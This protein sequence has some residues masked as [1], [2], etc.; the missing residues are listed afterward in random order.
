MTQTAEA[1]TRDAEAWWV[2]DPTL[3]HGLIH[4]PRI[5]A[6][7]ALEPW[8]PLRGRAADQWAAFQDS[9]A[10]QQAARSVLAT[11]GSRHAQLSGPVEQFL[12]RIPADPRFEQHN[13]DIARM[14]ADDA[15][16]AGAQVD[17]VPFAGWLP[18]E[19]AAHWFGLDLAPME[20]ENFSERQTGLL[21]ARHYTQDDQLAALGAAWQLRQACEAAAARPRLD[22]LAAWL[23]DS[24]LPAD[25]VVGLLYGVSIPWVM[26]VKYGILN[27]A[28]QLIG[29]GAWAGLPAARPAQAAVRAALRARP[30]VQMLARSAAQDIPLPRHD[31]TIPAGD[32]VA[33]D[34]RALNATGTVDWTFGVPERHFCTGNRVGR[35][36]I[37]AVIEALAARL[38]DARLVDP[39]P[40]PIDS[41]FH[42]G[43]AR[44][45]IA[46]D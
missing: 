30:P 20:L 10:G 24:G 14:I 40:P 42:S 9:P 8:S 43:P 27:V 4:D 7:R 17:L 46:G 11:D 22:T 32:R 39:D 15:A 16:T 13:R 41:R 23:T 3:A 19:S 21:W 29:D 28:W 5:T 45:L 37:L 38:P 31:V 25:D 2:H 12:A 33:F 36:Q 44:L 18:A 6:A 26:G 34:V 1:I 35:A